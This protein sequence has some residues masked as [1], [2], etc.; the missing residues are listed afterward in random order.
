M[1]AVSDAVRPLEYSE[2]ET[3]P[4]AL[5]IEKYIARHNK[6]SAIRYMT[7]DGSEFDLRSGNEDNVKDMNNMVFGVR[8]PPRSPQFVENGQMG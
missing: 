2:A 6:T 5:V 7:C 8:R 4:S 1:S 3:V